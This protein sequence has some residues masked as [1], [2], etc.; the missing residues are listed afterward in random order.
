MLSFGNIYL[1]KEEAIQIQSLGPLP[2]D[3]ALF[4]I[5]H[6]QSSLSSS[7]GRHLGIIFDSFLFLYFLYSISNECD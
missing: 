3:M 2:E 5:Y 6:T 7:S 4:H 1:P